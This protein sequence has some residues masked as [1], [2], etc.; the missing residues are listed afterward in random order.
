[1]LH[2]LTQEVLLVLELSSRV[3]DVLDRC[4]Y[5]DYQV[6][7]TLQTLI[8]RGMVEL[9][10]GTA[11][12][13]PPTG[14]LFGVALA[15][16]LRDWL[17]QGR[18][19]D[20]APLDAKV[21]FFAPALEVGRA[22]TALLARLP[23]VESTPRG[24]SPGLWPRLRIPVDDEVSIEVIEAPSA[25]R[26]AAA[27]PLAVHGALAALFVHAG[28]LEAS[29]DALRGAI[30]QIGALPRARSF[31]LV[32]DEKGPEAIA[33]LCER[34]ALFDDRNVLAVSPENPRDAGPALRE[35][36]ARWLP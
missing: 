12:P 26:F 6:L 5:P 25:P 22:F 31:H 15:A 29:V 24:G 13:E 2:P 35:L 10:A 21:V 17:D 33:Q 27:W 32:L 23:G 18:P 28:G 14:G 20:A 11:T 3:S 19:R 30:E 36:L 16:R 8:R 7:R 9:R 34:L 4:S 1:V